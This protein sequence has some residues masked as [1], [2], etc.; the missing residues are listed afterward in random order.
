[1]GGGKAGRKGIVRI[2]TTMMM[3]MMIDQCFA[4]I[5]LHRITQWEKNRNQTRCF[6][7]HHHHFTYLAQSRFVGEE[8]YY[9]GIY[10]PFTPHVLED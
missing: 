10:I 5:L 3:M 4:Q 6:R 1:M 9:S 7:H 8:V 2:S